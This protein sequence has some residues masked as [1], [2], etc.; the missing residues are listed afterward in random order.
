MTTKEITLIWA[1]DYVT[2]QPGWTTGFNNTDAAPDGEDCCGARGLGI[3]LP[4]PWVCT[5]RPHIGSTYHYAHGPDGE[6]LAIW[7]GE[8]Y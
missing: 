6:T 5:R 7:Q 4:W 1:K 2:P 8:S 3:G